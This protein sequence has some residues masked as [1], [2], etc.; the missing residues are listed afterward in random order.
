MYPIIQLESTKI[1][2]SYKKILNIRNLPT[3]RALNIPISLPCKYIFT[4]I[5]ENNENMQ[6]NMTPAITPMN[7]KL[8]NSIV[9]SV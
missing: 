3:P 7:I 4:V 5:K 2:A 6:R 9:L 8:I 1:N